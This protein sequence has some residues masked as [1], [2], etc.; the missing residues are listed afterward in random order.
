V[1]EHQRPAPA[2]GDTLMLLR[3]APPGAAVLIR[4]FVAAGATVNGDQATRLNSEH[5]QAASTIS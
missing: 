5:S 4:C 2:E 1:T 3:P